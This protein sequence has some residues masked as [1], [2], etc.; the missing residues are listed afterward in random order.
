MK[1]FKLTIEYDGIPYKGWQR[2]ND[3]PSVQQAIE[4]AIH[5]F[6]QEKVQLHAAGR[7]DSGVHARGQVAHFDLEKDRSCYQVMEGLN[8]HLQHQPI[9][10]VDCE[11]ASADFHARFSAVS[12]RYL[13][14]IITRRAPLALDAG[15]A[16]HVG[17]DLDTDAMIHAA[18]HFPGQHDFTSFRATLCQADSPVKTLD[19]LEVEL[20]EGEIRVHA[21]ARSFLHHQVRNMLGA[22]HAAGS[23]KLDPD[24]IPDIFAA[25]DRRAA[26]PTAPAQG[27][28]LMEVGY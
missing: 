1:R 5:A 21:Q 4:E 28:Y 7:T 14:R 22:L 6:A 12:R 15:R 11:E 23:G 10:I 16:W 27:L 2:Q 19:R 18:A 9:V 26:P 20:L 8:F 25:R 24:T 17:W 13:Y 3:A